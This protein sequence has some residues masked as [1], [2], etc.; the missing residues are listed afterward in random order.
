MRSFLTHVC[1]FVR[2]FWV[3]FLKAIEKKV[4]IEYPKQKPQKGKHFRGEHHLDTEKCVS[5]KGCA[6]SCPN[7]CITIEEGKFEID[8]QKCCFCGICTRSCMQKALTMTENEVALQNDR[9]NFIVNL[10]NESGEKQC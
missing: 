10:R 9:K 1:G 2:S 5:C 8:Y 6:M 4:T 7:Q 3:V